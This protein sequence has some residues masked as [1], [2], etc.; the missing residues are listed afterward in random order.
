M[1]GGPFKAGVSGS[2]ARA[3]ARGR[4]EKNGR[5]SCVEDK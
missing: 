5:D 1:G 4:T 3:A 2:G